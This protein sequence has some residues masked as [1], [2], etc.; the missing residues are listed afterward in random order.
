MRATAD[1][2]AQADNDGVGTRDLKYAHQVAE[3][4]KLAA[5]T[6]EAIGMESRAETLVNAQ[7]TGETSSAKLEPSGSKQSAGRCIL[8][9]AKWVLQ[10]VLDQWF[11]IGIGVVIALA[12]SF[13]NV[14]KDNG[15]IKSEYTISFLAVAIIFFISGLSLPL[16]NLVKRIWDWKLHLVTHI[17]SFLVFPA[18]VYAIVN[19]VRAADPDFE[20]F[21]RYALV[22]M[23]VMGSVPTTISSN[24]VMTGQAGGDEAAA[25]IEVMI[26]NLL[27]TFLSPALLEMFM[28]GPWSFG[29]PVATGGGGQGQIYREVLAQLGYTV[30]IPLTV[31]EV[32]QYIWP[33]QTK[34]TRTTLR[35]GKVGS[36]CLLLVI[37][38]TFSTAFAE[39]VFEVLTG[40]TIAF[41]VTVNVGL[42][43][44]H[45]IM[46]FLL[47]RKVPI[48]H[49]HK[50][51][52]A[53]F[54]TSTT[55]PLLFCAAAKGVALGGPIVNILYGG[56]TPVAGATVSLPLVIYQGSQVALGQGTVVLMRAW[57]QREGKR[58][59]EVLKQSSKD[60]CSG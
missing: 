28:T 39:N 49:R 23:V 29:K 42:Y 43:A 35:L 17:T 34:W 40:E 30:F 1:H 5:D 32:I 46:L 16:A 24:V 3:E 50:P 21:D 15:A 44:L 13:P 33:K 53:L 20:R 27:G 45:S 37:W 4:N 54:D 12:H 36:V 51:K 41:I 26:G 57:K 14:A 48:P 7:D 55:I 11:L 60:K 22:G 38:A 2:T 47:A 9:A 58:E 56:L 19:C 10:V 18:I 6:H 59:R 52:G 25:T 8:E 31:G